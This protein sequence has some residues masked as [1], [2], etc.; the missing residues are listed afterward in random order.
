MTTARDIMTPDVSCVGEK[1][2]LGD[3]AKKMV[4][5]Q[6]G[7]LPICGEDNRLKGMVTD[8]D[9]VVKAV[10]AGRNPAEMRA[11]ELST[12][13]P[14]TIGA[15]DHV[16]EILRTMSEH[17]GRSRN[18]VLAMILWSGASGA[19]QDSAAQEVEACP[20]IHRSFYGFD[21]IYGALDRAGAPD[22]GQPGGD[23]VQVA[24]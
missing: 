15:D 8:R 7:S 21:S 12:G 2:T 5:L 6:V 9:I 17:C 13:K 11:G 23:R 1:E 20:P 18:W 4:D 14:V 24:P 16:A 22:H 10:A 3:A 19:E